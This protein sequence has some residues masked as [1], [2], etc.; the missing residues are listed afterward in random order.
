VCHDPGFN[1]YFPPGPPCAASTNIYY[2]PSYN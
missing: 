1:K 2:L